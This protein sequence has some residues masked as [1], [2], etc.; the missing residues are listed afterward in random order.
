LARI[1]GGYLGA[2]VSNVS[3]HTGQTDDGE[4]TLVDQDR[5]AD[6]VRVGAES[7]TPQT[8]AEDDHSLERAIAVRF[9][10]GA[11]RARLVRQML[12]E[13][14]ILGCTGGAIGTLLAAWGL[15]ALVASFPEELPYWLS[16]QID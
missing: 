12:V 6:D 7:R 2:E 8:F 15:D 13:S 11:G 3:A 5:F 14:L 16:F 1:R 9:A 10:L 4:L